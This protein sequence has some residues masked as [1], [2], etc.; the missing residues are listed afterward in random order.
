MCI[1]TSFCDG[2]HR[3]SGAKQYRFVFVCLHCIDIT[4]LAW[5]ALE[6]FDPLGASLGDPLGV[7]LRDLPGNP[8][9]KLSLFVV[10]IIAASKLH[11]GQE[12]FNTYGE[13][14][15]RR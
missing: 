3:L 5:H 1:Y 13:N 14:L 12:I 11:A 2:C 15:F 8:A 7:S 10:Q 6:S 9:G 4:L